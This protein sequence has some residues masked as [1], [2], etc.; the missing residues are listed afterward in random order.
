MEFFKKK[1]KAS[2]YKYFVICI[3][4]CIVFLMVFLPSVFYITFKCVFG[5]V[6]SYITEQVDIYVPDGIA[7][8]FKQ[9]LSIDIDE[10]WIFRLNKE[11]QNEMQKDIETNKWRLV[12]DTDV[13]IVEDHTSYDDDSVI[14]ESINNHKCYIYIFDCDNKIELPNDNGYFTANDCYEWLFFIYDTE[15]HYYYV[16]HQSM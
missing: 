10:Y 8:E 3:V 1:G 9:Y 16:V 14:Y 15:T 7:K 6:D 2:P 4:V 12:N 11:E 5:P 13:T